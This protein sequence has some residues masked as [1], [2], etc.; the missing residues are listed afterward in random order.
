[1]SF[2]RA[3]RKKGAN[4]SQRFALAHPGPRPGWGVFGIGGHHNIRYNVVVLHIHLYSYLL[5]KK[6]GP[7]H[8][9]MAGPP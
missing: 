2:I 8:C 9:S 5:G 1:M 3:P 6:E 4:R 7:I